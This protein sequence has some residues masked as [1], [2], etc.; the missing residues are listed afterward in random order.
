[1]RFLALIFSAVALA[2]VALAAVVLSQRAGLPGRPLV[3]MMASVAPPTERQQHDQA[4]LKSALQAL[5]GA[6]EPSLSRPGAAAPQAL[7]AQASAPA[8]LAKAT[9]VPEAVYRPGVTVVLETGTEGKAVVDGRLVHVG[10]SVDGGLRVES[11]QVEAVTF[12]RRDGVRVRV[13]VGPAKNPQSEENTGRAAG[14]A[15][16]RRSAGR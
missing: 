11:I 8:V 10:D 4:D 5:L 16:P 6:E 3:P 7:F 15:V 2:V 12:T 1:M 13:A 9:R 14:A